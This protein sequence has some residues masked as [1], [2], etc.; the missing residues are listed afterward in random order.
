MRSR[1]E[2]GNLTYVLVAVLV[3]M[4]LH[5]LRLRI[6]P[7]LTWRDPDRLAAVAPHY[8]RMPIVGLEE[9]RDAALAAYR[10]TR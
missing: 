5:W 9:G 4:L 7:R 10:E 3:G 2:G 1:F 8:P 6:L